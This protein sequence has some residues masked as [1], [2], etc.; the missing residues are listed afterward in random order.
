MERDMSSLGLS[1][2][3]AFDTRWTQ[4]KGIL[5][6]IWRVVRKSIHV[7]LWVTCAGSVVWTDSILILRR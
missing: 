3:W 7:P 2:I 4:I 5:C 1:T 6:E